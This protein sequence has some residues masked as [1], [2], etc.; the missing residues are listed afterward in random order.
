MCP[1]HTIHVKCDSI[2]KETPRLSEGATESGLRAAAQASSCPVGAGLGLAYPD[3]LQAL[4]G[5]ELG[6][7]TRMCTSQKTPS[8]PRELCQEQR[9]ECLRHQVS[10]IS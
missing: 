2:S 3:A 4:R 9:R 10:K 7:F 8:F 5:S 6:P 1:I